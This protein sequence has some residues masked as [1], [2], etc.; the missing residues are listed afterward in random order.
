MS[1]KHCFTRKAVT[2]AQPPAFRLCYTL[3]QNI[4]AGIFMS[5]HRAFIVASVNLVYL[6]AQIGPPLTTGAFCVC[7]FACVRA[8]LCSS[9]SIEAEDNSYTNQWSGVTVWGLFCIAVVNTVYTYQWRFVVSV[10]VCAHVSVRSSRSIA[11]ED[12]VYPHQW[13]GAVMWYFINIAVVKSVDT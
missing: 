5:H 7:V 10:C 6:L 4:T 1:S 12:N 11:E 13:G 3:S 2:N 8:C 9:C